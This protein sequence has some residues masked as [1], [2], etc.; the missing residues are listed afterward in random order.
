M[1]A[2]RIDSEP[3]LPE[4]VRRRTTLGPRGL[5]EVRLPIAGPYRPRARLLR[6]PNGELRWRVRL[7]EVDR[8]VTRLLPPELVRAYAERAGLRDLV[9]QLDA[10]VE[11]ARREVASHA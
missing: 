1:D 7:W 10:A 9:A 4:P 5:A 11:S 3:V 2:L 8:P 6:L